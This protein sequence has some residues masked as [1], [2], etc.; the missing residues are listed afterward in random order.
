VSYLVDRRVWCSKALADW[1]NIQYPPA[2]T[3]RSDLGFC[4]YQPRVRE[5]LQP[6]KSPSGRI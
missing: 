2:T 1:V 3:L 4:G 6:K 5:H